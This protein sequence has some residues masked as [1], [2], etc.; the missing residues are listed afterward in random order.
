V[1]IKKPLQKCVHGSIAKWERIPW[2]VVTDTLGNGSGYLGIRRLHF[3]NRWITWIQNNPSWQ[4]TSSSAT[5]ETP[6][7]PLFGHTKLATQFTG[8]RKLSSSW[9]RL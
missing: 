8:T 9:A 7:A 6:K 4:T 5:Q 3:E 2:E 1:N